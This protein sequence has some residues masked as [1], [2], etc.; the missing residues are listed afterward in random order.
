MMRDIRY[1][2]EGV[3]Y[4]PEER[5]RGYLERSVWR[6]QTV[7]GVLRE[8]ASRC[9]ERTA[10]ITDEGSLTF[11]E[12][13]ELTDRLAA[14]MLRLGLRAPDRVIFQMGT[15]IETAL[16]LLACYKAGI[17]PVCSLPQHRQLE[18]GALIRQTGARGYFVQGDFGRADLPDFAAQMMADYPG[19]EHLI[20]ARGS[21][22]QTGH[23]MG[24]MIDGMPLLQAREQLLGN[25]PGCEDVLSFQLSGGT[26][27]SPKIIPRF[28]AEYLAH[29]LACARRYRLDETERI[30]WALPL[31][32]NAAQVYVLMP[33]IAM[34]VSAVLMPRVDVPRMMELI[35]QHRVTRAMSIGPIAP[36]IMAYPDL[37]R[38]DLSSLRLFIT[39]SAADHLERHLG[40]P[41]SN[42]FGITEGLLLGSPADAPDYVR[43]HTQGKSGCVEDE[44]VLLEPESETPVKPGEMGE[45]CFRGPATLPGFFNAPDAN[46]RSFTAHG[47]Y[48]TGDMMT[49]HVVDGDTFYTFEGRLRDNINRGGE[50]I[51]CEEVEALI[52][53]HPAVSEARLVAMPDPVYG[54]KGCIFIIP[55]PGS[56]A[57]SVPELGAF[58]VEK[59][60]AKYKC[61]ER[62][63]HI[64]AF[65]VTKVGKLDKAALR[66]RIAQVLNHEAAMRRESDDDQG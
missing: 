44:I 7:G 18:I 63:E 23:A 40:V 14:A 53:T 2:I 24:S 28:H 5:A 13:D 21:A 11:R 43:H 50:K 54:E 3:I 66:T 26:T 20:V 10:L 48:R 19:V 65:P 30:I 39:M 27:G 62:V 1:P 59:G 64:D 34:G 60:L 49:A 35:D 57:P 16:A 6:P 56:L 42:L 31:L 45:L 33:V 29:A 9:P 12:L 37:A 4:H 41:C 25:E 47:F 32:H 52:N 55:R 46:A 51:G 36:Q 8:T 22:S 61:P 15:T 58:L 38:H 17:V